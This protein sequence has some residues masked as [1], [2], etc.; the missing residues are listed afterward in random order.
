MTN[1]ILLDTPK[2]NLTLY[3]NVLKKIEDIEPHNIY[4]PKWERDML[5]ILLERAK[6]DV[7]RKHL[8]KKVALDLKRIADRASKRM[9]EEDEKWI[10]KVENRSDWTASQKRQLGSPN[11][12]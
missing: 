7:K 11:L 1:K 3:K 12:P 8:R 2:Y 4:F 10:K 5:L 9:E 6:P